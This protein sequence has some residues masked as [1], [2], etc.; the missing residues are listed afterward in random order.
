MNL[1]LSSANL[2]S[3]ETY[4]SEMAELYKTRRTGPLANPGGEFLLFLPISNFT[5]LGPQL[6]SHAQAQNVAELLPGAPAEVQ[7]GYAKQHKLLTQG[8]AS[9]AM[10]PLEVFWNDGALVLGLEH[11]FSRGSVSIV[12]NDPFTPPT[13]DAAYLTNPLDMA[14]LVEAVKF[15][16]I[17]MDTRAMASA[18]AFEVLP[19]ANI[20]SNADVES[21]I[22]ENLSSF[23]HYGGTAAMALR[24]M[25]GV[26]DSSFRVYGVENLRVI[27]ASVI[28]LLPAAHT[29]STVYALAEKVR[30]PQ[31]HAVNF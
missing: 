30:S 24:E 31:F 6:L 1:P 21:F 13:I 17:I 10:T 7:A 2:T 22:K 28:P 14:I 23:A 9:E 11:P 29:S 19:G 18:G 5:D 4:A 15:A 16:R 25:G 27:D 8:L 3:N 26:V 20:T 12:S